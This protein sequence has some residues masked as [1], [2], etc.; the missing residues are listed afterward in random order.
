VIVSLV[1]AR[2]S[3]GVIGKD[4]ALPWRL[5][6]DMRRFKAL[7]LG[8][9]CVMGRRTWESLPKKPLP[10]RDNIV[11]TRDPAFAADGA[12]VVHSL[13]EALAR[14]AEEICIIGGAGIYREALP[15]ATRIHLTEIH[16]DVDGDTRMPAF[17]PGVWRETARE[18]H[19]STDGLSYSFVT[20]DRDLRE[21]AP[22]VASP[23]PRGG[24]E[25]EGS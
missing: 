24:Q 12:M 16:G 14:D 3:N 7:T 19:P 1:V 11:V 23:A 25:G 5:P 22:A 9:P 2:A 20:L 21:A 18:D 6:E 4:G 10:G 15:R 13:D 17:D 8:K